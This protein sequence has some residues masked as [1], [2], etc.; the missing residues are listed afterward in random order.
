M[1]YIEYFINLY[2]SIANKV[3]DFQIDSIDI[4]NKYGGL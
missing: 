1:D 2:N 4:L 3:K